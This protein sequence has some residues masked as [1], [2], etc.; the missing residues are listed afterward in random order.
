MAAKMMSRAVSGADG[1]PEVPLAWHDSFVESIPADG[2]RYDEWLRQL[3]PSK[4]VHLDAIRWSE[5]LRLQRGTQPAPKQRRRQ[6]QAPPPHAPPQP[7]SKPQPQPEP[8]PEPKSAHV[9]RWTPPQ[10]PRPPPL[11]DLLDERIA[12]PPY[13]RWTPR[14]QDYVSG[15]D[16][17]LTAVPSRNSEELWATGTSAAQRMYEELAAARRGSLTRAPPSEG[18]QDTG[19]WNTRAS[20]PGIH[21]G[22]DARCYGPVFQNES[23]PSSCTPDDPYGTREPDASR[24]CHL[25][26]RAANVDTPSEPRIGSPRESMSG[27]LGTSASAGLSAY[28]EYDWRRRVARGEDAYA[29][30][31]AASV[32]SGAEIGSSGD[33]SF[34]F[35]RYEPRNRT[36]GSFQA[37]CHPAQGYSCHRDVPWYSPHGY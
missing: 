16:A 18:P 28:D 24:F 12:V 4:A 19:N 11:V 7:Q 15:R 29:T 26:P 37:D 30:V 23:M 35:E 9:R 36:S 10:Q 33:E 27:S 2:S 3:A 20:V 21:G 14:W 31:A 22:S 32:A 8:E 6:P 34:E 17:N 5:W 25:S 1:P 13:R